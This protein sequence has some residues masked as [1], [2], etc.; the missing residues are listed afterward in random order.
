L[1]VCTLSQSRLFFSLCFIRVLLSVVV[2]CRN[3]RRAFCIPELR[4]RMGK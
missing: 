4:P 1:L 2:K 3:H